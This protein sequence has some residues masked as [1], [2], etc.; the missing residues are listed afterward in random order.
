MLSFISKLY[1]IGWHKQAAFQYSNLNKNN[2]TAAAELSIS[3]L[4]EW[5][6]LNTEQKNKKLPELHFMF[7]INFLTK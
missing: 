4:L 2:N 7:S 1:L 6:L 3:Y 5:K